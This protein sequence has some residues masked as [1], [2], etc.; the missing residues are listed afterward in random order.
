MSDSS[1]GKEQP[2]ADELDQI[3]N[4]IKTESVAL[5]VALVAE[6]EASAALRDQVERLADEAAAALQRETY[7]VERMER[8]Q[9]ANRSQEREY[10]EVLAERDLDVE[11]LRD[12]HDEMA[13]EWA[14]RFRRLADSHAREVDRVSAE[15]SMAKQEIETLHSEV[16]IFRTPL[17][18]AS[19]HL[20]GPSGSIYVVD[21]DAVAS[22]V[23]PDVDSGTSRLKLV[24]ATEGFG[25][26]SGNRTELL[27]SSSEG[28]EGLTN[29]HAF[30]RIR[31]PRS[32][33]SVATVLHR[34]GEVHSDE[35]ATVV[36]TDREGFAGALS[37][38]RFA[39]RLGLRA[40]EPSALALGRTT[41]EIPSAANSVGAERS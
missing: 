36:V 38:L 16:A 27:F 21:G 19:N 23:W 40:S 41:A 37:V 34:L 25:R 10:L 5:S 1:R 18:S 26:R 2:L 13:N 14:V 31:V 35:H 9:E 17:I 22:C 24:A 12:R 11:K 15:L 32:D 7:H 39:E 6:K 29:R 3:I 20:A 28:M 33:V 4:R 8:L 30:V